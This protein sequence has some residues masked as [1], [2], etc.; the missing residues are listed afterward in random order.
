V[1][2][3]V[4]LNPTTRLTGRQVLTMIGKYLAESAATVPTLYQIEKAGGFSKAAPQ[5][6]SFVD[7]QLAHGA[8]E[9]RTLTALAWEDSLND[10]VGYPVVTV[11]DVLSGKAAF[12]FHNFGDD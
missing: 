6:V 7:R 12:A 1:S 2:A 4:P 8:G 5:A 11:R 3:Y 9:F 10:G